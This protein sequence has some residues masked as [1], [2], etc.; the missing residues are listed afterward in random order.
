MALLGTSEINLLVSTAE[1]AM[2]DTC[3]IYRYQNVEA[4]FGGRQGTAIAAGTVICHV[5]R[6]SLV[7]PELRI[8]AE[9]SSPDTNWMI[10]MPRGTDVRDSDIITWS[11]TYGGGTVRVV[12]RL[13]RTWEITRRAFCRNANDIQI[14]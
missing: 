5:G 9:Q 1:S 6:A 7:T 10:L 12:E 8:N 2:V 4:P 14:A 13:P 11:N 3:V